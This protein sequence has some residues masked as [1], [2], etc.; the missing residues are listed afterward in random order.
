MYQFKDPGVEE[1]SIRPR[2]NSDRACLVKIGF[3]GRSDGPVRAWS[4]NGGPGV[5]AVPRKI[6]VYDAHACWSADSSGFLDYCVGLALPPADFFLSRDSRNS[7][8]AVIIEISETLTRD[9]QAENAAIYRESNNILGRT[10]PCSEAWRG[11]S[12]QIRACTFEFDVCIY[13]TPRSEIS[14]HSLIRFCIS[15]RLMRYG[16]NI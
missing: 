8:R 2:E 6:S 13:N 16:W 14:F 1:I 9:L 7:G 5:R 15:Q 10:R 4:W 12:L 11:K 3:H